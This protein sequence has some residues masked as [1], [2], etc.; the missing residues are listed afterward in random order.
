[1]AL[2]IKLYSFNIL[3][4]HL[5]VI[6][7]SLLQL[8]IKLNNFENIVHVYKHQLINIFELYKNVY[9][10]R[11]LNIS[12]LHYYYSYYYFFFFDNYITNLMVKL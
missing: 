10:P 4:C 1:M 3:K 11:H 12:Q 2:D 5:Y 8:F 7:F 9:L 6:K